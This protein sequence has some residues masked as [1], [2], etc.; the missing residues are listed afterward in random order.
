MAWNDEQNS[1]SHI[2]EQPITTSCH[3]FMIL[4]Q[5]RWAERSLAVL[6]AVASCFVCGG[7]V[8]SKLAAGARNSIEQAVFAA[9][10]GCSVARARMLPSLLHY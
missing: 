4:G 5:M 6:E 2:A 7:R 1:N 8:C 3:W 9:R 10:A